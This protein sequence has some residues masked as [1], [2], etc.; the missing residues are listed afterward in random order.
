[1]IN[2]TNSALLYKPFNDAEFKMASKKQIGT[3]DILVFSDGQTNSTIR[4]VPWKRW[5]KIILLRVICSINK[6]F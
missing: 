3:I 2:Y 5:G 6:T 1:M 4:I